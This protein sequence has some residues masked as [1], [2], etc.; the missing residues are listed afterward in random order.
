MTCAICGKP[1]VRPYRVA[2]GRE[3]SKE[4]AK[5]KRNATQRRWRSRNLR[6]HREYMREWRADNPEKRQQSQKRYY[7][8]NR[9]AIVA[10]RR[11]KCA[12]SPLD[13]VAS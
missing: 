2:C 7:D 6:W 4:L 5:Q 1:V 8:A 13:L 11:A 12:T 3:H 9:D 10:R